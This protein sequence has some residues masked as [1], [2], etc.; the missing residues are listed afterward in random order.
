M[1]K[2]CEGLSLSVNIDGRIIGCFRLHFIK[3]TRLSSDRSALPASGPPRNGPSLAMKREV[4]APWTGGSG[5]P[6]WKKKSTENA[7]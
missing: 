4:C 5:L 1:F 3:V 7:E 2:M 6:V